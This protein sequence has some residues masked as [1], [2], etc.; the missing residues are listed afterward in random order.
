M[1]GDKLFFLLSKNNTQNS[2]FYIKSFV[3][4]DFAQLCANV[5]VLSMF[6]ID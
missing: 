5:S 2:A 6:K 4:D 1:L 3:F